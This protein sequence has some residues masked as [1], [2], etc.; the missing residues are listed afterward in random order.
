MEQPIIAKYAKPSQWGSLPAYPVLCLQRDIT[1]DRAHVV[2]VL[3]RPLF[4]TPDVL[5]RF[6][7]LPKAAPYF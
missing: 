1:C 6:L 3:H 5:S 2:R 4:W 7:P